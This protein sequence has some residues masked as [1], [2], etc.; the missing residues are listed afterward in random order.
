MYSNTF[1]HHSSKAIK[2]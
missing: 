1:V 2:K